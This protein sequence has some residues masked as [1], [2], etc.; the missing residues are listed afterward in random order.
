MKM[1][2]PTMRTRGLR[3][4]SLNGADTLDS[5]RQTGLFGERVSSL[6]LG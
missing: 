6:P 3:T 1:H 2:L 5:R 4:A